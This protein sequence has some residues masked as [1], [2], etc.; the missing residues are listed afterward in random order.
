MNVQQP[1][2]TAGSGV[3]LPG[4]LNAKYAE[5]QG[6][7]RRRTPF[8][9]LPTPLPDD[10]SSDLNDF[11]FMDTSTQDSVAVIDACLHNLYDVPRAKAIFDRL[12]STKPNDPILNTRLYN[13]VLQA[14]VQMATTKDHMRRNH[15]VEDACALY[16]TMEAGND[17]IAPNANTYAMMLLIWHRFHPDSDNPVSRTIEIFTPSQVLQRIIERGIPV[18]LVVS[19]RAFQ[20]SE[21]AAA[22]I[23]LLSKAAAELSLAKVVTEL[24]A[25]EVLGKQIPDPLS[26]VPEA[27]PVRKEKKP[28]ISV[29][30]NQDGEIVDVNV[31]ETPEE[32]G[33]EV[34]FNL[35][36]LRNHLAAVTLHRRV[37]PEDAAAR[38][39][40]LEESVYDVAVERWKHEAEMFEELGLGK[41]GL[42]NADLRSWMWQWHQ[43]LQNRIA[44]EIQNLVKAEAKLTERQ[45][46]QRLSPFLTLIKPEKL[47]LIT[48]LEIMHLHG[49]GGVNDGM[50][51][52]RALIAVGKAVEIEYK[53]EMCKKNNIAVPSPAT[54]R[55]QSF[56]SNLGYRAL[57]E[58][59]LAARKYMEDYEEW[60]S[61]W[62]QTVR[63]RVGSFL[64]DALMDVATITRTAM[65]RR[66]NEL[67]TEEQ[68]AFSHSYEYL[69]GQRLGVIKL[70]PVVVDRMAKDRV[71]ETLHPR[72]LPMLVKPK[73]WLSHD[74]GGYLYNKTSVMRY[75]DSREQ[76]SYVREASAQGALELVYASLDV[77]GSTPWKINRDIFDVVLKV[78]NSGERMGKIPP[79]VYDKPE[80]EKPEDYDTDPK[81][82][83][84]YLS[85]H[86]LYMSQK[87]NNHSERC[88]T[89][90]KIEIARAF[91][92][93][94]IYLPHNVDFRG[95]AYPIPPNLNHLGDDL[96][97][98][99]LKF[100]ETKPLGE[101]GL[102]WM[103]IHL[104]NLYGYD[105]AS[106]DERVVFVHEH[107]D[108]IFDSATNPLDGRG[109]WKKADDPWQCLA[110]CMELKAALDSPDPTKFESGLPIHQDGTCNGLQHYAAL[111]G[112]AQGA[113]Q[114][115]LGIT[116]RPS[117]VYT[118][119]ATMVEKVLAKDAEKGDRFAQ[120][121]TGKI[122]RK[123][124]KQT[125]MTTVYGVTFVGARDQIERQLRDRGDIPA[126]DCWLAAAYLAKVTLACIGDLFT[127]A[128][129]IQNWLTL[130]AKLIAKSIPPERIEE[131]TRAGTSEKK[132]NRLRKEQMTSV[133]WTTPLGLPIVQP[134]RQTK[135]KQ[136]ATKLQTVFIAD[137][138]VPAAVNTLKQ[139]SAFP[140]NFIHSLDATH[141]ML[142]ALQCRNRDITFA[143]VHDSYWTHASSV[144][145]M[146]EVIRETFIALH[147]SDVLSK[148]NEEFRERY[149]GYKVP[150]SVLRSGTF[151]KQL[152]EVSVE[153]LGEARSEEIIAEQEQQ[154]MR[155]LE[156][157]EAE[158]EDADLEA[159][160][161]KPKSKSRGKK[162][163]KSKLVLPKHI[164]DIVEGT[165]DEA[166]DYKFVDLV[167]LIPP[168]PQKGNFDVTTIKKSLYFFS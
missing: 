166:A 165:T 27:M 53:A 135:R 114:V 21:E 143:S 17:H 10:K 37:L 119:V 68:P 35:T 126:E 28:I 34:P 1:Q 46:L 66:T 100:A 76:Q 118:H 12:R 36:N 127:G 30:H 163:G 84:T 150:V 69:R 159:A 39:K 60:T 101:R 19:D 93:D 70:N 57:H 122:A 155:E 142:T 140:P 124:V 161:Q 38:Q 67:H 56:F 79:A 116:D 3:E 49:T 78:W 88:N 43:K 15:W 32:T 99:L 54:S 92:G 133:I 151:M 91:L 125:V 147:S 81:A 52:A 160:E 106:F 73:P 59:R 29:Q 130:T 64:V 72:H 23:K 107:L 117:D 26:D 153:S 131:V 110:T 33:G 111:G 144:D 45:Q 156:E 104:A 6:F 16:E 129:H 152:N 148:L 97:R 71:R 98:G 80:P 48:I 141:M 65:D 134:Y 90:Y 149:K 40:L 51:T 18:T 105:K 44:G 138:N 132:T 77:L 61:E 158:D 94:T 120:M 75:K 128:K 47:S 14:Y 115:N 24:G 20:D 11:Y 123:V 8:T 108:D 96:S 157:L 154:E 31:L 113:Q 109:W 9:I 112:D 167:D 2:N 121:L 50:K 25:A 13:S 85:R 22:I 139:A 95:R 74:Q 63:V 58:R 42:D 145:E 162:R 146:S 41:K 136:I 62:T 164:Q 89:N 103:K 5:M 168:L 4:Q 7:L 83:V 87:A 82:R 55:Q 86:K 137:P 102:R